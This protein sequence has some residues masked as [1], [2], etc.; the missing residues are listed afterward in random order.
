M[1]IN[2][3]NHKS[4]LKRIRTNNRRAVVRGSRV[5]NLRS[6]IKSVETAIDKKDKT[7]AVEA[8]KNAE[9][10]IMK[11]VSK[12]VINKNTASR[13]ISRLSNRIKTLSL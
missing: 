12:G 3:D 5:T 10:K 7:E 13:K 1:G 9:S 8:F 4:A 6:T 2:L 11:G